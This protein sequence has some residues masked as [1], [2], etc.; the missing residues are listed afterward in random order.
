MYLQRKQAT[1]N[2]NPGTQ[3][4]LLYDVDDSAETLVWK[5]QELGHFVFLQ[6]MQKV[7]HVAT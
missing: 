4:Y 1:N 2:D 5:G 6:A 3:A 7:G